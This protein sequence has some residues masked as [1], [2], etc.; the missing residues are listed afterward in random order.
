MGRITN[1]IRE[2]PFPALLTVENVK[3]ICRIFCGCSFDIDV[4]CGNKCVDGKS[5]IGLLQ[6]CGH[7]VE[8][9]PI[10][11]EAEGINKLYEMLRDAGAVI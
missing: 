7:P 11:D 6:M 9:W 10:A 3:D 4:K 5:V 8:I 2:P 1:Y